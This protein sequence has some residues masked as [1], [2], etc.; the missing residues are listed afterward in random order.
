M[1]SS[2][3]KTIPLHL[4]I[5]A[6]DYCKLSIII[7]HCH[8]QTR[9]WCQQLGAVGREV[10]GLCEGLREW[11]HLEVQGDPGGLWGSGCQSSWQE[12]HLQSET[13]WTFPGKVFLLILSHIFNSRC[14]KWT[15]SNI[16]AAENKFFY[17][18]IFTMLLSRVTV[19]ENTAMASRM[20]DLVSCWRWT[21]SLVGLQHL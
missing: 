10:G 15:L 8:Y 11:D 16:M 20:V 12:E 6:D 9:V 18:Y 3:D 7:H 2:L 4:V 17:H 19:P 5:I 21:E 1:L 13:N 14:F